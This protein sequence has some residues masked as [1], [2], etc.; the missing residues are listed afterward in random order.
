MRALQGDYAVGQ[1]FLP[2]DPA[3][4]EA[5]KAAVHSVAANQG[6]ALLGWRKVPTDNR[7][8]GGR[9]GWEARQRPP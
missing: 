5:A 8:G 6:H 7:W 2:R 4:Y 3:K 1:V 9:K